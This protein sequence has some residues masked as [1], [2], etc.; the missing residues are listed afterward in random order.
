LVYPHKTLK[1]LSLTFELHCTYEASLNR[2]ETFP[3]E[4]KWFEVFLV[5]GIGLKA[6]C[7]RD[8][9]DF[10]IKSTLNFKVIK[11]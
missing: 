8:Y 1:S 2:R 11:H 7:L 4:K 10:P 3:E 9:Q 5:Y 6:D